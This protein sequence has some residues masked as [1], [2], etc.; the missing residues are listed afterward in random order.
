MGFRNQPY[1]FDSP[2]AAIAGMIAELARSRDS[3]P[4]AYEELALSQSLGRVLAHRVVCDRDSPPFDHSSM[5][6]YAVRIRD[7]AA[8]LANNTN[9]DSLTLAIVGES[10]IG[11]TP[12]SIADLSPGTQTQPHAIR[13]AT[14]APVP[15][16]ID[17]VIKREETIEHAD[18][19]DKQAITSI[20]ISKSSVSKLRPGMNI[21]TKGENAAK[22]ATILSP[23]QLITP[24]AVGAMASVGLHRVRVYSPVR[25]A[26]ITTGDEVVPINAEPEPF[27][28][29]NSNAAAVMALFSS[30]RWISTQSCV[31]VHDSHA[32]LKTEL[33][34]VSTSADAIILTGGVSMGHRD[35]VRSVVES[36][37]AR[38]VFHGLPQR[39]GKPMLGAVISHVPKPAIPIFALPGNPNSTL[40]TCTRI[41]R[42][43][44]AA[45]AGLWTLDT[46]RLVT[47]TNP[48][49]QTLDLYWHRLARLVGPGRVEILD[50]RSSGDIVTSAH[51]DG[52]VEQPPSNIETRPG[53][54]RFFPWSFG[55]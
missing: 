49:N 7:L 10:R 53:G 30:C 29:R 35:P 54:L 1:T 31:H 42:P 16:D 2:D 40:V 23:G 32:E 52:F 20:T 24:A 17:A 12:P 33:D 11:R 26:I 19:T 22:G 50:A 21:R 41:V 36:A 34:Q 38:I 39:P 3:A 55:Q 13:I 25:V 4:P 44:L 45:C 48:D 37:R 51:S 9:A 15:P 43:V 18:E 6:G 5:D 8:A 47:P 46:S 27:Q 14:G 28:I